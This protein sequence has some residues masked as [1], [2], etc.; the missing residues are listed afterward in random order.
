MMN[1]PVP[2]VIDNIYRPK[3]EETMMIRGYKSSQSLLPH[4]LCDVLALVAQEKRIVMT[5]TSNKLCNR[6]YELL[7]AHDV[8]VIAFTGDDSKVDEAGQTHYKSKC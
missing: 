1:E 4:L 2:K 8:D 7:Q 3:E 6:L 5:I